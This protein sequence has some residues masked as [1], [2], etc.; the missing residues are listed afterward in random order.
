MS[1][2]NKHIYFN[3]K[4]NAKKCYF[5]ILF[6]LCRFFPISFSIHFIPSLS[7]EA[8]SFEIHRSCV[9]IWSFS[10]WPPILQILHIWIMRY[11]LW[12]NIKNLD[13]FIVLRFS[14]M[15]VNYSHPLNRVWMIHSQFYFYNCNETA[16][17][18]VYSW[19]HKKFAPHLLKLVSASKILIWTSDCEQNR[20]HCSMP[21]NWGNRLDA[22]HIFTSILSFLIVHTSLYLHS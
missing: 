8:T 19:T 4:E 6:S 9:E 21:R 17:I 3:E 18:K 15:K 11:E 13:R 16:G 10:A 1:T 7:L 12:R 22:C 20:H 14:G 5:D 2:Y